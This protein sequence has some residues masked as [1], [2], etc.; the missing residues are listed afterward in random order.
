MK[1]PPAPSE[2]EGGGEISGYNGRSVVTPNAPRNQVL[3]PALL[4]EWWQELERRLARATALVSLGLPDAGFRF[5]AE[6]IHRFNQACHVVS[7]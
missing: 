1:P 3:T 7:P 6:E 4:M 2:G 5:L